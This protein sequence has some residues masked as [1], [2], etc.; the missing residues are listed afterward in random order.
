MSDIGQQHTLGHLLCPAC[1]KEKRALMFGESFASQLF[2]EA[3]A[4]W[5]RGRKQISDNTRTYYRQYI[6][7]LETF[8][9]KMQ[10]RDIHVGHLSTYQRTRQES[11]RASKRHLAGLK[12]LG[13]PGDHHLE[14]DGASLI[15][16]EL[17]CLGQILHLAGLWD[18]VKKFY[19]PL[20]LPKESAAI[21]LTYEEERHLFEVAR[22]NKRWQVAYYCALLSRNTTAGPG[23]IRHLRI[24][25]IELGGE[26]GSFVHI[27]E[28]VK[29]E[30]RKRPIPL[31][32]D[33]ERA[34]VWMLERAERLGAVQPHHYLLPHRAQHLGGVADP[35]RPMGSWKRA[36]W[37]M[38]AE[39]A[40]KFPR[41]ARMRLYDY[42]HTA[43]TDL[44]ED[45]AISYT[46]IEHM[47]GHRISSQT[48]RKYDHLRNSA[49]RLAADALN[50]RHTGA[51]GAPRRGPGRERGIERAAGTA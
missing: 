2:P 24:G 29:N 39:A 48:K 38:C 33:A 23:E 7:S 21:A 18:D 14:S 36:H 49:L 43:A 9:A 25:D 50:R 13:L 17:S 27:V 51:E 5:L 46:T 15:N 28:G 47:M 12:K 37:A 44:M 4:L 41:I 3:A 16:H 19:E 30:F 32:G 34:I 20:P 22:G 6:A 8:F 26:H 31:N 35:A 11:I 40:K 10:L 1:E 45:P 42:R